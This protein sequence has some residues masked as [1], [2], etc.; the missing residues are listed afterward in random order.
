MVDMIW[1]WLVLMIATAARSSDVLLVALVARRSPISS[2]KCASVG[3]QSMLGPPKMIMC[4]RRC[5]HVLRAAMMTIMRE[6]LESERA[7]E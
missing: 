6:R 1:I 3:T 4:R 5:H 7:S 2:H